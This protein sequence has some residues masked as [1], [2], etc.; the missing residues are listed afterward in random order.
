MPIFRVFKKN[1]R[2]TNQAIFFCSWLILAIILFGIIAIKTARDRQIS[3]WKNQLENVTLT[4]ALQSSQSIDTATIVLNN[5]V[6]EV[7]QSGFTDNADF[8]IKMSTLPMHNMI[9]DRRIGLGQIDVV[10]IIASNGDNLNFSR[11]YPVKGI[12]LAERDYFK[13]HEN[14]TN[15][16]IHIS[17]P[18]RNKGNG[19]WTF[20]LS[21]RV[22]DKQG[23]FVGLVLVGLSVDFLTEFYEKISKNMGKGITISLFRDDFTL[24]ARYPS[25]DTA[26]G[27]KFVESA[28]NRIINEEKKNQDVIEMNN[29]RLTTGKV[30]HRLSAIRRIDKYP[31]VSVIVAPMDLV[32]EA[33]YK[34][35]FQLVMMILI[36]VIAIIIGMRYFIRSLLLRDQG[37]EELALLKTQAEQ[38]N[39]TKS[40]F[41]ATMSHE[42]RTPLNGILGM[43]QILLNQKVSDAQKNQH[44]QTIINSGKSLQTLLNDILDFSKVEA[45]KV[46][47]VESP[48]SP[49]EII[50]QVHDLYSELAKTKE[51]T[52]QQVWLGPKNQYY[53]SDPTRLRQMLS[54]FVNNAIKFTDEGFVRIGA[55]EVSREGNQAV[56]EFA[57]TDTG[58]GIS[59]E[60]QKVLFQSF[61]QVN[62]I[63]QSVQAGSGL[64][65]SIVA[66]LVNLMQG[67][68]GVSS[69]LG[70]GSTF[71]FR[72]PVQCLAMEEPKV[73]DPQTDETREI[74]FLPCRIL[75]VED[76]LTN[77]M[78]LSSM[79]RSIDSEII[80]DEVENGQLAVDAY[81]ENR[82]YDLVLMDIQ[83]PVMD[84]IVASR[85]IREFESQ[86]GLKKVPI[87]AVTAYAYA[88]DR[89]KYLS[90]GMD[91]LAKPIEF[92]MLQ[93]T[94]KSWL[95]IKSERIIP[96][97]I[98]KQSDEIRV[99]D[100]ESML[101]RLGGDR[102]LALSIIQSTMNEMPKFIDQLYTLIQEGD[103]VGVK[104]ITHTL[105][106]LIKQVGGDYLADK[107]T[108]LD[109][110]L[111]MGE[112]FDEEVIRTIERD[113]H[114]L[115]QEMMNEEIIRTT[116]FN[117]EN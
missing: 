53:L 102:R 78:V 10:S 51:I 108:Q 86:Q 4:L 65:L 60:D 55:K 70:K 2:T 94:L 26:I 15:L 39:Q 109:Y 112:Y 3:F 13:A 31:L 24:L 73:Y 114:H 22:N 38:A 69:T 82:N 85:K 28:A 88:E 115:L 54:N 56:I 97:K 84:G 71:W 113:Y 61:S 5:V 30:E 80:I 77:R 87:V 101:Q 29:I 76:N 79:I 41:L 57:V 14:D 7:Y 90:L 110:Q 81:I 103:W 43:A 107:I 25:L 75:I 21:K 105:K 104:S 58:M 89:S 67:K 40:K 111:K 46:E 33:W 68:Y 95:P 92:E 32:L 8:R 62:L 42:I 27:N 11:S 59:D 47:L 52:L 44:I 6:E 98:Q 66:S 16:E 96:V 93:K 19:K 18:V 48:T 45:G 1:S 35:A 64:G 20:Y 117:Q 17:E 100:K 9:R 74:K 50:K 12:N 91:F 83:L 34:I 99:F 23:E 36:G 63:L 72:I 106:G 116:D 49:E 37:M